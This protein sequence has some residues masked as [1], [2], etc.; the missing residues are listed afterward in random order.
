MDI[1]PVLLGDHYHR[2]YFDVLE[3]AASNNS[4]FNVYVVTS[5]NSLIN[6][7]NDFNCSLF[8]TNTTCVSNAG[9]AQFRFQQGKTHR[10]RLMNTGAAALVH[11]SIDGHKMQVI[12]NDF[13][14]IVP[15]EAD[16]ITLGAAQRTDILVTANADPKETYWIRSTISLNCSSVVTAQA[17]GLAVL[18]YAGN[19]NIQAPKSNISEAAALADVK[20]FLCI[21]VWFQIPLG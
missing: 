18:S 5:D 8:T 7:K 14:P 16:F 11:F 6:G 4:D 15:Y 12:T 10:L 19:D 2:D 3:D 13:V 9:L 20:S 21:N 1:G 17:H